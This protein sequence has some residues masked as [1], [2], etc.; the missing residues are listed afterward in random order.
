MASRPKGTYPKVGSISGTKF[1]GDTPMEKFQNFLVSEIETME[2]RKERFAAPGRLYSAARKLGIPDSKVKKQI[3]REMAIAAKYA[4]P[5]ERKS[6]DLTMQDM[7][8]GAKA[9]AAA[10]ATTQSRNTAGVKTNTPTVNKTY[11]PMGN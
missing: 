1:T 3:D 6:D 8:A 5:G 7:V 4:T 2:T 11:R 9:R 10:K